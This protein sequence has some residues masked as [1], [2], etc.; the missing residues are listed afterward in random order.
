MTVATRRVPFRILPL[1]VVHDADLLP[2]SPWIH[3]NRIHCALLPTASPHNSSFGGVPS[4]HW[5][6]PHTHAQRAGSAWKFVP[7]W[8]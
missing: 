5:G 4:D 2:R 8:G 3:F 7:H 6:T 1:T